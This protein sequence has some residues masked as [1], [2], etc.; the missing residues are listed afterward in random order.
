MTAL[1]K[2][3]S[4]KK[5]KFGVILVLLVALHFPHVI[6]FVTQLSLGRQSFE[7]V[8]ACELVLGGI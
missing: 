2:T 5:R 1:A 3:F 7:A 6:D 4:A 8:C